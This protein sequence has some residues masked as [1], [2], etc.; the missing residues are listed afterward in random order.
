MAFIETTAPEAADGA[1]AAMY[2]RQQAAWGFIPNYA[3]VCSVRP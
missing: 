3:Q 1:V 2:L